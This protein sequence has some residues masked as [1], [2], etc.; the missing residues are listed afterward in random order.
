[1]AGRGTGRNQWPPR[2]C[3]FAGAGRRDNARMTTFTERGGWWVAW[4]LPVLVVAAALPPWTKP[5]A[6]DPLSH[7]VRSLAL[8]LLAAA[9]LLT[10]G[11]VKELGRSLTPYPRPRER[12]ELR[13]GGPY[14][15][16]RHPL[17][18]GLLAATLGWA[19]LWQS[20]IGLAY[21]VAVAAFFDRKAAR[22]ERWMRERFPGYEDYRCRVRRFIPGVY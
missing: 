22:E 14:R 2:R 15:W 4:Q 5:A 18:V 7:P 6:L 13:T 3:L 11:A 10:L 12:G 20:A 8:V 19:L 1:M 16:M 17:Y 9:A 21:A